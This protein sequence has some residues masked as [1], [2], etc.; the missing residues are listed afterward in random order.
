MVDLDAY[1]FRDLNTGKIKLKKCF[2]DAYVEK[3]YGSAH[4]C[5]STTLLRLIL[6]AKYKKADLHK[7]ME[8]KCQNLTMTQRNY[9]LKLL[10]KFEKLFDGTLSI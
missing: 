10:Q 3:I 7:V 4:V 6:D 2:T 1:V 9:L 8:L 5:A